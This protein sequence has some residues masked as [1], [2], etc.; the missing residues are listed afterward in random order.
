[1]GDCTVMF[2]VLLEASICSVHSKEVDK[3]ISREVEGEKEDVGGDQKEEEEE[4]IK[5]EEG[6]GKTRKGGEEVQ[7]AI[8]IL[9]MIM[10]LNMMVLN[11]IVVNLV[12]FVIK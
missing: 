12:L 1:M 7:E 2:L 6:K 5:E 8:L 10:V 4:R 11:M 3:F 9:I